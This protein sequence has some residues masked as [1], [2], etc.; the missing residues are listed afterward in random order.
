MLKRARLYLTRNY[1]RSVLLLLLMLAASASLLIGLSV[2]NS[3]HAVTR[4]IE[5][6]LGT[7][8][9]FRL[10]RIITQDPSYG[11]HVK[12][13]FGTAYLTYDGP[14]FNWDTVN[15]ILDQVDGITDYN[16][17][18][19]QIMSADNFSLIPGLFNLVE[20]EDDLF[21]QQILEINKKVVDVYGNR[22]TSL[23][24]RFRTGA[25]K[26]VEGRHI[27]PDDTGK[28]LVSDELADLNNLGVGDSIT[29]SDR[30]GELN[31]A[32]AFDRIGDEVTLEIVGIFHVN[33]YQPTGMWVA[34]SD[35]TYNWI[36]ADADTV[37]KSNKNINQDL[38]NGAP[39]E[40]KFQNAT[41]FVGDPSCLQEVLKQIKNLKWI[42]TAYY[43]ISVD[44]TMFKSSVD[45]LNSIRNLVG[46]LTLA[47]VAGCVI[48]LLIVFTMWVRSRRQEIAV[49]LSMGI[50]KAA[51]LGQFILEAGV[52]AVLAGIL[53]FATCRNVPDAI[54]NRM[55][56]SRIEEAQP[57]AQEVTQEQIHQAIQS[58]TLDKL[59]AY[60]SGGYAGPDHIDFRIGGSDFAVVLLLE[61]LLIAGAVCTAGRFIFKLQPREIMTSFY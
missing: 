40:Q 5:Q 35:M 42:D 26:I 10:S 20:P 1:K 32:P 41:F 38:Y 39:V 9:N 14:D 46:G 47:I 15:Q 54:G 22:D 7:S 25:F 61:L 6:K 57:E 18:D 17:E 45:P 37:W 50:S 58:G 31:Q 60:Q 27:R 30:A 49:Y 23:Y 19:H 43:D 3:I 59:F 29:L 28:A 33:G 56:A 21:K 52:I 36:F 51:I 24:S 13:K 2:W 53:A 44:D 55:L 8:I 16:I 4:E 34:E 48:V 11:K 12:S